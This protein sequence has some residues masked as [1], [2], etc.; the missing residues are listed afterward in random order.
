VNARTTQQ[1]T[2]GLLLIGVILVG[3]TLRAPLTSVGALIPFIRDGLGISNTLAGSITTLPLLGFAFL[4]PFAPTLAR[5]LGVQRTIAAALVLLLLGIALRSAGSVSALFAGTLFIG[6]GIAVGNVLIP[7][8]VKI[9]FPLKVGLITGLYAVGMNVMGALGSGLSV[10]LYEAGLGW[11]GALAIWGVVAALALV[12]WAPQLKAHQPYNP[13]ATTSAPSTPVWRSP[14]AWNV[15]LFM[16]S[17][18]LIFYC[19]ITW[20][21]D[22]LRSNGYTENA[23]GWMVFLMQFALIPVTFAVPMLAEKMKNQVPLAVFTALLFATGLLGL[24]FSS[25]FFYPL[26]AVLLGIGGGCAFSL[27][28]MLFTLRT[29]SGQ[30]AADLSGMAQSI[31][32]LLAALGPMLMG[33]LYDI[34]G[35]WLLPMGLLLLACGSILLNGLAAG[36]G[37]TL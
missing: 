21:P 24:M 8:I 1:Q 34:S 36:R 16:G 29:N 7:A 19:L 28:M 17:Q 15:T 11:Q 27:S 35:G 6:L 32:Y 22:F 13:P 26:W 23:A 4:S 14:L 25:T 3:A 18:S 12:V 9:N 5:R 33:T 37:I 10:P 2:A 31:G 30:E 20:M